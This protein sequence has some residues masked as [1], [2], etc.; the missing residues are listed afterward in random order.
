MVLHHRALAGHEVVGLGPPQAYANA[1]V[2][3]LGV[4]VDT[5]RISGHVEAR[6]ADAAARRVTSIS[7]LST[8]AGRSTTASRPWPRGLES[9]TVHAAIDFGLAHDLLDLLG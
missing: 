6:N 2:A 1:Q 3:D 8:V 9:D 7:A 4:V 5:A